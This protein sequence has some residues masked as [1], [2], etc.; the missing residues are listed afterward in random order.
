MTLIQFQKIKRTTIQRKCVICGKEFTIPFHN[1]M[2]KTCSEAC[3]RELWLR[4]HPNIKGVCL[5]C[6]KPLSYAQ[7]RN[8]NKFCSQKCNFMYFI[9][10]HPEHQSIAGKRGGKKT[11]SKYPDNIKKAYSKLTPELRRL[12]KEMHDKEV[13]RQSKALASQGYI[14]LYKDVRRNIRP[15]IIAY[16]DGVIYLFD[17]KTKGMLPRLKIEQQIPLLTLAPAK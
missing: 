12:N 4:N 5:N 2:T 11:S 9:K 3:K 10:N 13:E 6:E 15:D 7:L 16:K 1:G 8:G 17:V 14:I